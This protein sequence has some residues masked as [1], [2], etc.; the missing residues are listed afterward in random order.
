MNYISGL[1]YVPKI[2]VQAMRKAVILAAVSSDVCRI[3][4]RDF[5]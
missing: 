2:D 4:R 3:G 1:W 5:W